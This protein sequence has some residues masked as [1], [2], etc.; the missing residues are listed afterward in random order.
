MQQF[1]LKTFVLTSLASTYGAKT[2]SLILSISIPF[3]QPTRAL[4]TTCG[5][6][7]FR[8]DLFV[9]QITPMVLTFCL[10]ES[11]AGAFAMSAKRITGR[12]N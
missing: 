2:S 4:S 6:L 9:G 12:S 1:S 10:K 11:T 7:A 8:D 5:G 3:H